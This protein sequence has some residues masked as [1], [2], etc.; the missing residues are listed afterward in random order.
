MRVDMHHGEGSDDGLIV[1]PLPPNAER[2]SV[3]LGFAP[4]DRR[5]L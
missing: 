1:N 5:L 2:I 4:L 3:L